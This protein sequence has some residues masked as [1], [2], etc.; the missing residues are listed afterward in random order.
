MYEKITIPFNT[1]TKG[2]AADD[3]N[4]FCINKKVLSA[5][6]EFF[7]DEK[8]AYLTVFVEYETIFVKTAM[9]P[10]ASQVPV[11]PV[12]KSSAGGARKPREKRVY[13]PM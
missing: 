11:N 6:I 7:K 1:L 12:M 8:R 10:Q 5:K 3:L 13:R 2:F 4:A 9:S